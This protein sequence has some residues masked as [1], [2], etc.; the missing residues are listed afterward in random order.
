ML[1]LI[2]GYAAD[3]LDRRWIGR[4]AIALEITGVALLLV[5][6]L[7][8]SVSL[9]VVFVV[10]AMLGVARALAARV[11]GAGS[12][13]S[14]RRCCP[15]RSRSARWP[16]RGER[17]RAGAGR[18]YLCR[19][20]V[21]CLCRLP[22]VARA[23]AR[24]RLPDPP[25][26]A[27]PVSALSPWQSVKEGLAYVRTNRVVFGAVTLDLFAVLLGG[28]TALLPVFARDVLHVGPEGL[29]HLRAAPAAGAVV[30]AMLLAVRPLRRHMG[31]VMFWS[32]AAF[33][34]LTAL[35]GLSTNFGVSLGLLAMLGAVDM[36]SVY[37]RQSIVQIFVPDTMRGRVA[38]VSTLC[39]S[40]SNELGEF[41]SGV[42][43]RFLGAVGAVVFG[44][45]GAVSITALWAW[46]F[47]ELR[48]TDRLDSPPHS[49]GCAH[50]PHKA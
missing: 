41:E 44:G 18:L 20:A 47:P 24:L 1:T 25:G 10:A 32:V 15:R 11:S 35:F 37:V 6:S 19:R 17:R 38:S 46:R 8:A 9:P 7:S 30:I 36:V 40:A 3:R 13:W 23:V 14:A 26:S 43:A 2:A 49:A 5:E 31:L 21:R 28:A 16:G 12:I 27:A 33:G 34:M 4:A 29:G 50:S 22:G 39:I 48:R 42:A 45:V